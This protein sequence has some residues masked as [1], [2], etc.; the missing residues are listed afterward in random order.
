MGGGRAAALRET[1]MNRVP[2]DVTCRANRWHHVRGPPH[3][4]T[5]DMSY[6]LCV[7]VRSSLPVYHLLTTKNRKVIMSRKNCLYVAVALLVVGSLLAGSASAT[8]VTITNPSFQSDV[9]ADGADSGAATTGWLGYA[10][11]GCTA[12]A[13]GGAINPT[14]SQFTN[15]DLNGTPLGA[16]GSNTLD[17]LLGTSGDIGTIRQDLSPTDTL[18][19]G[20]Y[21]LTIAVGAEFASAKAASNYYFGLYTPGGTNLGAVEGYG[22]DLTAGQL[23]EKSLS[24]VVASDNPNL[25]Q[26]LQVRLGGGWPLNTPTDPEITRT[27]HFDNVRLDFVAAPTPEPG[28]IVLLTTG[29]FG[30]LAYAWRKRK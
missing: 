21:T 14:S 18:K 10:D 16:D 22:A 24:I 25:G 4:K 13:W 1:I 19:A 5:Q 15:A 7:F 2:E 3:R 20:T 6:Y 29:L 12:G 28:T 8:P 23:V 27:V 26:A 11:G 9:L 17:I 30:L